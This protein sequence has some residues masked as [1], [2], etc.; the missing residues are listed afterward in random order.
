MNKAGYSVRV[1]VS[2]VNENGEALSTTSHNMYGFDNPTADKIAEDA[3]MKLV[4]LVELM[5]QVIVE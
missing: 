1:D 4:D 2:V 5:D 3:V